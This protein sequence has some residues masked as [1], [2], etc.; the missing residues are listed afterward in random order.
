M[1]LRGGNAV[2]DQLPTSAGESGPENQAGDTNIEWKNNENETAPIRRVFTDE[3]NSVAHYLLHQPG[4]PQHCEECR[5]AK[6]KRKTR[7]CKA[8]AD[9]VPDAEYG[10]NFTCEHVNFR[11]VYKNKIVNG[12]AE[13]FTYLD[14]HTIFRLAQLVHTRDHDDT[15]EALQFMK[16]GHE[17]KKMYSD[18]GGSIKTTCKSLPVLWDPGMHNLT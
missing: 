14:R 17:W 15:F 13:G 9:K 4:L 10:E 8:C 5:R 11:H 18:N 1:L 16:G 3:A 7:F 6:T 12:Y 2:E